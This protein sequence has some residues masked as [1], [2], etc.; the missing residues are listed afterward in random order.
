[1]QAVSNLQMQIRAVLTQIETAQ[2]N[3][4]NVERDLSD[5]QMMDELFP[6]PPPPPTPPAGVP[7][8]GTAAQQSR[9]ASAGNSRK[10]RRRSSPTNIP[11]FGDS[12]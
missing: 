6:P 1:M 8:V 5:N 11:R 4:Q 2:G 3:R 10:P 12:A 9:G 7:V